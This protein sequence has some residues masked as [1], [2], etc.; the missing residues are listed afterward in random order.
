MNLKKF[1]LS[2]NLPSRIKY[3]FLNSQGFA[4]HFLQMVII[5]LV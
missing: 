1:S 4:E 3:T 2:K 5:V